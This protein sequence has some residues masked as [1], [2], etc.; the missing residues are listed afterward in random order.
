MIVLF[1]HKVGE[2]ECSLKGER[3]LIRGLAAPDTPESK[4][5]AYARIFDMEGKL[6]FSL[7]TSFS[8][9]LR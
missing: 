5:L 3:S 9:S 8:A 4:I 7:Q 2:G 6:L 1:R